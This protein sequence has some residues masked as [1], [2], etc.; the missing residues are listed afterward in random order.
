MPLKIDTDIP[1]P[2]DDIRDEIRETLELLQVG[3]S[4]AMA[5]SDVNASIRSLIHTHA[6]AIGIKIKVK[7]DKMNGGIRV[8]RVKEKAESE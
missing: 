1:I 2:D 8:F 5:E 7:A 4:F 6:K 3:H